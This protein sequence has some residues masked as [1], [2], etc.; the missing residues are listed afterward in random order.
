MVRV[1][2]IL[3]G[4]QLYSG[5]ACNL[6]ASNSMCY[7]LEE[8]Y[9]LPV[10]LIVLLRLIRDPLAKWLVA[11]AIKTLDGSN[12]FPSGRSPKARLIW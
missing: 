10:V 11:L 5:C 6:V 4:N 3:S 12:P 7:N 2:P 8:G 9:G 1:Y